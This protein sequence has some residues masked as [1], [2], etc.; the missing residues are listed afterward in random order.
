MG[1]Q[2]LSK[3]VY[4]VKYVIHRKQLY[5]STL[6]VQNYVEIFNWKTTFHFDLND[7]DDYRCND[8]HLHDTYL[9]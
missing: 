5:S 3:D 4:T 2:A 8:R 7:S 6:G 9:D 1:K